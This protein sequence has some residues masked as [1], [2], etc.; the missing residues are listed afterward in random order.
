[1]FTHFCPLIISSYHGLSDWFLSLR[2]WDLRTFVK[3]GSFCPCLFLFNK[4]I[5]I[6]MFSFWNFPLLFF[7]ILPLVFIPVFCLSLFL[8]IFLWCYFSSRSVFRSL[9][10]VWFPYMVLG[11]SIRYRQQSTVVPLWFQPPSHTHTAEPNFWF[12]S[13]WLWGLASSFSSHENITTHTQTHRSGLDEVILQLRTVGF[14]PGDDSPSFMGS[15]CYKFISFSLHLCIITV[16]RLKWAFRD[17]L[18][19]FVIC[20]YFYCIQTCARAVKVKVGHSWE[21]KVKE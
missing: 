12:C 2:H 20:Y 19:H 11:I 15:G 10:P 21:K 1:M 9:R 3:F 6:K 8:G 17:Y 13:I 18:T 7:L 16:L 4:D 14:L 5:F